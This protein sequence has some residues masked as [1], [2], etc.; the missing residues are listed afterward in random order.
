MSEYLDV[1]DINRNKL[2]KTIER[3][4][5]EKLE[6]GEFIVALRAW[7]VN[8]DKKILFTQRSMTKTQPGRWE[9]TGGLLTSGETSLEGV[10]RELKEEIG[11]DVEN[12]EIQLLETIVETEEHENVNIL[13]DIYLINKDITLDDITFV[14]NEVMDAKFI[15]IDE[16]ITYIDEDK[17][18]EWLRYF[19][20]IYRELYEGK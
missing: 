20:K 1:Y 5:D 12:N 2:G 17:S 19:E 18:F 16:M 13:R 8:K 9:P 7:V 6:D 15:T 4:S 10:K 14:D 11:L 3:T